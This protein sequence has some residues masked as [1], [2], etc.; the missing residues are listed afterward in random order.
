MPLVVSEN[1]SPG[2]LPGLG[3]ILSMYV[4]GSQIEKRRELGY[5]DHINILFNS[6]QYRN[7]RN[8]RYTGAG[9]DAKIR[10][11]IYNITGYRPFHKKP[12]N[13]HWQASYQDQEHFLH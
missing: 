1:A 9:E 3:R 2:G 6:A 4:R 5:E 12:V 8:N 11:K 7:F 13:W 10:E